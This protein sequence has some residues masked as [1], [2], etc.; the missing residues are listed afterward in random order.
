MD[1]V[2][3]T[4]TDTVQLESVSTEPRTESLWQGRSVTWQMRSEFPLSTEQKILELISFS[5][6][7]RLL[8]EYQILD[9]SPY[10]T[11][12]KIDWKD[13]LSEYWK[14]TK[15][16]LSKFW[17]NHKV[18]ILCVTGGVTL[19]SGAGLLAALSGG[20][21]ANGLATLGGAALDQ[22]NHLDPKDTSDRISAPAPVPPPEP[23]VIA[24][25]GP[26][27]IQNPTP[28]D[29]QF[30][31][32]DVTPPNHWTSLY[33]SPFFAPYKQEIPDLNTWR[34]SKPMFRHTP[35]DCIQYKPPMQSTLSTCHVV[36]IN[37]VNTSLEQAAHHAAYL[38]QLLPDHNTSWIY[39]RS[40]GIFI[41]ILEVFT[42]NYLGYSPRTVDKLHTEWNAFH[43]M[44]I[45][46]SQAKLFQ[47]CHSQ[48]AIH[49][50][51][52]LATAPQEIRDRVIVLAIAPAAVIS[53]DLCY[54][55]FNYASKA[56]PIPLGEL[57]FAGA[58]SAQ[59]VGISKTEE[60]ILE[61]RKQLI[62]LDPH[63]DATGIDHDFQSPTFAEIIEKQIDLYIQSMGIYE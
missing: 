43:Q 58:L 15:R 9:D 40:N 37:G 31:P 17:K 1:E 18:E 62:L 49:V 25:K 47:I 63:P 30:S 26:A 27:P 54:E 7:A 6:A 10:G 5:N 28:F 52:A 3:F 44:H 50:R 48:G 8:Y 16:A 22:L 34:A 14:D 36:G 2:T 38:N 24:P 35:L 12:Q 4:D 59:E 32:A 45:G 11:F 60:R 23:V 41:D 55:S 20:V 51:N 46:N 33:R 56:D 42:C 39:N 19:L 57:V 29:E 21:I 13:S 61:D 53:K